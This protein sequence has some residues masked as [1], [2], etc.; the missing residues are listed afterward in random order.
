MYRHLSHLVVCGVVF[1]LATALCGCDRSPASPS[2]DEAPGA[3][4]TAIQLAGSVS[5]GAW[6]P[7]AGARVEA[8]DGPQ[9]GAST[10]TD[11]NGEYRLSGRFDDTTHFRASKDGHVASTWPLPPACAPCNPDW[12]INFSL[13][14]LASHPNLAGDYTLT[15][16]ANEACTMLP[17]EF[18][19]RSY[20]A[21]VT[22]GSGPDVPANSRFDVALGSPPFLEPYRAFQLGVAGNYV[23]AAL[24][25]LH[26]TPGLAEQIAST[27]YFTIGGWAAGSAE[28]SGSTVS[29]SLNGSIDYCELASAAGPHAVCDPDNAIA[30]KQCASTQHQL[31]LRR[32]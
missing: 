13:E 31:I 10:T 32:R 6:R 14:S 15:V 8:V 3:E 30:L 28:M 2:P 12:W 26:G 4:G 21:T 29:V 19:T 22:M 24:G 25:D 18:R 7:L 23:A 17:D 11:G 1:G 27:K 20:D 16:I 9:A 5:D